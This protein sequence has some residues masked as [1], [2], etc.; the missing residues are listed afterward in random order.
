VKV[1]G[2]PPADKQIHGFSEVSRE[3]DK[4]SPARFCAEL[5]SM[6]NGSIKP[7]YDEIMAGLTP[8]DQPL[9]FCYKPSSFAPVA[10][11]NNG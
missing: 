7:K 3:T 2:I 8:T 9:S 10:Q 6:W 5:A 1:I 11:P 4:T